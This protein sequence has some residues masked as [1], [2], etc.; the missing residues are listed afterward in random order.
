MDHNFNV[1]LTTKKKTKPTG[2]LAP[3]AD[4]DKP[5]GIVKFIEKDYEDFESRGKYDRKVFR[6]RSQV[7]AENKNVITEDDIKEENKR[8]KLRKDM[9][10]RKEPGMAD[11][12]GKGQTLSTQGGVSLD[13]QDY[14]NALYLD[15]LPANKK[16]ILNLEKEKK[17]TEQE[18][19]MVKNSSWWCTW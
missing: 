9:N 17:F 13:V 8:N 10:A 7:K 11:M 6:R 19:E 5:E 12:V 3:V 18:I 4:K 15:N 2:K 14:E 1:D 16:K